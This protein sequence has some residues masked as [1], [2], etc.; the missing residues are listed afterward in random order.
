MKMNEI[1][2]TRRLAQNLTLKDV[3]EACRVSEA[4]VSRWES[5]DIKTLRPKRIAALSKVLDIPSYVLEGWATYEADREDR[6]RY[7]LSIQMNHYL[8]TADLDNIQIVLDLLKKL[9]EKE[10]DA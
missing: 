7:Q 9:E 2:R 5:G 3:A 8:K 4:T 10:K 6:E 1:I